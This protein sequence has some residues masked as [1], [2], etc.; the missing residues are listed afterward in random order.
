[1]TEENKAIARR[2]RETFDQTKGES[3]AEEFVAPNAVFHFPGSPPLNREQTAGMIAMFYVAFPDL[4]H[5]F[6]HGM[7][8]L[9][10]LG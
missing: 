6:G 8:M 4:H 2:M 10:H 3:G 1:M 9:N 7:E 5:T